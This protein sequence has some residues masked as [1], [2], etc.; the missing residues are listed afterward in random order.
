MVI[1]LLY[2]GHLNGDID[3]LKSGLSD[4]GISIYKDLNGP[5]RKMTGLATDMVKQLENSSC[6]V[7][8]SKLSAISCKLMPSAA[9]L[10]PDS[11][12]EASITAPSDCTESAVAEST[13]I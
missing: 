4:L 10:V 7:I 8:M 12:S 6:V 13:H 9:K 3:I 2:F 5:L 1:V 11:A